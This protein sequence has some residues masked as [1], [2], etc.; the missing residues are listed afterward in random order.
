MFNRASEEHISA[1]VWGAAHRLRW[2]ERFR[3]GAATDCTASTAT[4]GCHY[5]NRVYHAAGNLSLRNHRNC[6]SSRS[7]RCTRGNLIGSGEHQYFPLSSIPKRTIDSVCCDILDL[8]YPVDI[9]PLE[10]IRTPCWR[11]PLMKA[12]SRTRPSQTMK[13]DD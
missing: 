10:F 12:R 13:R 1:F 11:E 9:Y 3:L 5:R 6:V 8:Q 7:I 2:N 4:L